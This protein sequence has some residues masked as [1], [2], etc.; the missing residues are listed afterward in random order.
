MTRLIDVHRHLWGFDWFPPTHL[1]NRAE[2]IAR[3]RPIEVALDRIK[4][5]PSMEQTGAGAIQEM[6]YYGI[7]VSVIQTLDWGMAYGPNED[8]IL[9]AEE[10]HRLTYEACKRYPGKLHAMC[11]MDPRRGGVVQFFDKCV[12]E[13]GAVGYKVYP[14]NGYQA[15]ADFCFPVY[16]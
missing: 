1:R 4:Q 15:N 9:P 6:E 12:K 11:G 13:Y 7:D 10:F 14:P 16:K 2:G 5:S 3:G 8:N